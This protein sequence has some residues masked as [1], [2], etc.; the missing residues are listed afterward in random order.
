MSSPRRL[1]SQAIFGREER[2]KADEEL[3]LSLRYLRRLEILHLAS[4]PGK[5]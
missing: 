5:A 3:C 1:R 4:R 2:R